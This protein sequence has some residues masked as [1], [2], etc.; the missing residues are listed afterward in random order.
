MRPFT[1]LFFTAIINISTVRIPLFILLLSIVFSSVYSSGIPNPLMRFP[2]VS[3][4]LIVFVSGED[5][6]TAPVEGGVATRLT[7][8]DGEE[9][10]PKFSPD[11]NLIAFTG[12]YDGNADVYVMNT[13]GGDITRVTYHPGYDQVVGWHP[14][15]NKIIFSSSRNSF[16]GFSRLFLISPDGSGLEELI[17]HEAV[18]GSFSPDGKQIA[19]NRVSRENRTWKRYQGGDA[20][21]IYLFNFETNRDKKITNFE[22]TDRIPMWIGNKIYFSSDRDRVLNIYAYNTSTGKT[23]Q[24]THHTEYDVRRPSMGAGKIVYELGGNIWLLD[25]KTNKTTRGPIEIRT[26]EPETRPYLKNV[27]DFLTGIDC[28][29]GGERALLIARGEIFS[30]PREKGATRNLTGSSGARDKDAV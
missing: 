20:Q 30:V 24:I 8:H 23:E 10:Y 6:W 2:N 13:H 4:N 25:T 3:E 12:Y 5:I 15:K 28:S 21:D 27:K 18:Q 9:R 1:K 14:L 16:E 17:L 11:G 29:P 22:G 19:Y 7:I 26:D